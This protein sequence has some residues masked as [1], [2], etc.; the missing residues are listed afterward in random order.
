VLSLNELQQG[1]FPSGEREGWG[2]LTHEQYMLEYNRTMKSALR[3]LTLMHRPGNTDKLGSETKQGTISGQIAY[4][5]AIS[6]LG[7]RITISLNN[8]ADFYIENEPANGVYF[9]LNGNSNTSANMSS[10]GT[11]DGTMT[12]TGMYPGRVYYDRIEIRGGAAA[13]GTYGIEPNGFPRVEVDW[14]WGER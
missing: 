1:S 11:M 2:A 13:G 14:T 7:A 9:V 8:Y 6:G 12:N 3:K 4:N 5:A 10:I